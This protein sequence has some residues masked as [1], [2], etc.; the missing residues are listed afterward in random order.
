MNLFCSIP[1]VRIGDWLVK[2]SSF[3]D[4]ILVWLKHVSWSES[5]LRMFYNEEDAHKFLERLNYDY[6]NEINNR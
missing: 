6:S 5:E 3:D 2:A 1:T 4:Q